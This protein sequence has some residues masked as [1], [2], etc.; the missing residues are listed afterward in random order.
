MRTRIGVSCV[1]L[2]ISCLAGAP[3]AFAEEREEVARATGTIAIRAPA[4]RGVRVVEVR[5]IQVTN[6][7]GN[8]PL[9]QQAPVFNSGGRTFPSLSSLLS[10]LRGG[11]GPPVAAG[12]DGRSVAFGTIPGPRYVASI[13]YSTITSSCTLLG[14]MEG[15]VLVFMTPPPAE[16]E[17]P[18]R[19]AAFAGSI[20][21]W[22]FTPPSP[23]FGTVIFLPGT[24]QMM[25]VR[26]PTGITLKITVSVAQL[27]PTSFRLDVV[28]VQVL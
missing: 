16:I 4:P 24:T 5:V 28:S 27:G 9:N 11:G 20:T 3:P 1:A 10:A 19:I 7:R 23:P 22:E 14:D 18:G 21:G 2:I 8:N 26:S 6:L 12:C 17:P 15:E 13:N 25:Y